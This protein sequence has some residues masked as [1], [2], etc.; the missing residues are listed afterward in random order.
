MNLGPGYCFVRTR[1]KKKVLF[2][3]VIVQNKLPRSHW[4]K[5]RLPR[6]GAGTHFN[7]RLETTPHAFR[8]SFIRLQH[9]ILAWTHNG[10]NHASLV[11]FKHS[12]TKIIKLYEP[13]SRLTSILSF[14]PALFFL[15][16]ALRLRISTTFYSATVDYGLMFPGPNSANSRLKPR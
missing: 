16:F 13:K 1:W 14:L 15:V 8:C 12:V 5:S 6:H 10:G 11:Y 4:P 9:N 2:C 3:R 7:F